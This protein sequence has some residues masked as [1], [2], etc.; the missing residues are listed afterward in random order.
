MVSCSRAE[1]GVNS[2]DKGNENSSANTR[3]DV[4]RAVGMCTKFGFKGV[5]TCC[6]FSTNLNERF[7]YPK[8]LHMN[9]P[10]LGNQRKVTY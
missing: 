1:A 8:S 10:S 7:C 3:A 9:G 4:I 2:S 6:E 5:M